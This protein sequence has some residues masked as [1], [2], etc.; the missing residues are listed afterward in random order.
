MLV[1]AKPRSINDVTIIIVHCSASDRPEDDDVDVIRR[2]HLAR[3]FS[4]VGYHFFIKKNGKIQ[5]GRN[6]YEIG[7][8]CLGFNSESIGI[9]L[10][11]DKSF[12]DAQF[13]AAAKLID[14]LFISLPN[15]KKSYGVLPHR[16]FNHNKTCPNFEMRNVLSRMT[17]K[18]NVD[19]SGKYV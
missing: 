14:T 18:I 16:F 15:L 1:A 17:T 12:N 8:H 10:S 5:I 3:G 7:A 9:C 2:W 4:D 11:G 6:I 19:A 13:A